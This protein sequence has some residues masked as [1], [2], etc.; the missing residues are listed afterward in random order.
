[1][2]KPTSPSFLVA[3]V[4]TVVILK[5]TGR[6]CF[7]I[8]VDFKKVIYEL[9]QKG[10]T[11]FLLDLSRC[12][13]MD[14]T[15]LGIL[16][17]LSLKLEQAASHHVDGYIRLLNPNERIVSLLDNLGVSNHFQVSSGISPEAAF[18]EIVAGKASP[19][20]LASA[21]LE[22]HQTLMAVNPEN[23]P[24]FKDVAEFLAEDIKNL[25]R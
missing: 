14:S 16:T 10:Y 11:I 8:S 6:A 3:V 18:A 2:T 4:N 17:G 9:L 13:I 24:K 5:I 12:T 15:F 21:S 23:I 25:G 20:E 7:T 1:M 19:V 22:A